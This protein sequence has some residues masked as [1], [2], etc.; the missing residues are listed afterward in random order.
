V[1]EQLGRHEAT[2]ALREIIASGGP[3]RFSGHARRRMAARSVTEVDV[4]SVLRGGWCEEAEWEN[5]EW[6]HRVCTS[7]IHVV[8]EIEVDRNEVTIITVVRVDRV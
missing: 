3:I 6:R 8:V 7:R 5:G 4:L 2:R 1:T